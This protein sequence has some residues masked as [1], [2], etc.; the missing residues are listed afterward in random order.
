MATEDAT[1]EDLEEFQGMVLRDDPYALIVIPKDVNRLWTLDDVLHWCF[2]QRQ[3]TE[4]TK[5]RLKKELIEDKT[6]EFDH[7]IEQCDIVEAPDYLVAFLR[8]EFW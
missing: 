7:D 2:Y 6:L 4:E 5:V 8:S 1:P 3:P